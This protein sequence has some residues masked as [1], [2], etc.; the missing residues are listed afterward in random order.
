M[1]SDWLFSAYEL[2][3]S[4]SR[5]DGVSLVSELERRAAACR[6]ITR[7]AAALHVSLASQRAACVFLHRFFMRRSLTQCDELNVAAACLLLASKAEND[8]T[9]GIDVRRLAKVLI[10]QTATTLSEV[11]VVSQLVQ[12]EGDA[13]LA[14]S[15]ELEVDHS[16]CYIAAA[17][18]KVVALRETQGDALRLQLKQTAWSFLNDS[19][20]TWTC[21]AVD[22]SLAAKAAVYAAG[23]FGSCVADDIVTS[24]GDP[25][26]TVLETS[27]DVLKGA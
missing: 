2:Q 5:S 22:A 27:V 6:L 25:W 17:V 8:E 12:L 23:L 13:L 4:P 21:L 24:S 1:S 9:Q 26:W 10:T 15:F 18:D 3:H 7:L 14:L 20:I 16:F 11:E 19:A